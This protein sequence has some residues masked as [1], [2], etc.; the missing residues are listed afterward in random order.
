MR[1]KKY[2]IQTGSVNYFLA[3][4]VQIRVSVV[5]VSTHVIF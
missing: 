2:E 4:E 5:H 3:L 1:K